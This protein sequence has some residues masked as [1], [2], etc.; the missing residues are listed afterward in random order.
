MTLMLLF[1][2]CM[3]DRDGTWVGNPT[4]GM[5]VEVLPPG[6]S[7]AANGT[8]RARS[9][10]FAAC[11]DPRRLESVEAFVWTVEAGRTEDV[12]PIP[13]GEWCSAVLELV[14]DLTFDGEP[15]IVVPEVE[16]QIVLHGTLPVAEDEV[17]TLTIGG[18][19]WLLEYGDADGDGVID[20]RDIDGLEEQVAAGMQTGSTLDGEGGDA[21]L[22]DAPTL[23]PST[24][25]PGRPDSPDGVPQEGVDCGIGQTARL[26]YSVRAEAF[27][28]LLGED[29]GDGWCTAD[30]AF[31]DV[32]TQVSF[33]DESTLEVVRRT[34]DGASYT[35]EG[36]HCGDLMFGDG[37]V[38]PNACTLYARCV[39]G[40]ASS[41][42]VVL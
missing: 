29:G 40:E 3:P 33:L 28:I 2:A 12:V 13:T 37:R 32:A 1:L 41:V 4:G 27:E 39:D 25:E 21:L 35:C 38:E 36:V 26:S 19:E 17:T 34:V 18:F 23:E 6:E 22:P 7:R 14:V 42:G 8:V 15:R 30:V 24:P 20:G 9:I 10:T 31:F 5:D 11:D 16:A